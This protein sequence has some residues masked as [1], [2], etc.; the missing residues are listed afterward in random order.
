MTENCTLKVA[1]ADERHP[2]CWSAAAAAAAAGGTCQRFQVD[3]G[4]RRWSGRH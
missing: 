4:D 1:D 2:Y 3:R